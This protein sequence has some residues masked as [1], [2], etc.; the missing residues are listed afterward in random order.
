VLILSPGKIV[1][2]WVISPVKWLW[3]ILCIDVFVRPRSDDIFR[4]RHRWFSFAGWVNIEGSF[5]HSVFSFRLS[6]VSNVLGPGVSWS[7]PRAV[8]LDAEVVDTSDESKSAIF[9]PV[10][11]PWV[12]NDPILDS[13][14]LSPSSDTDVVV[15]L[16]STSI[17]NEDAAS[18][19]SEGVSN[20]NGTSDGSSLIDLVDHILLSFNQSK[21]VNSI[22]LC[23]FLSPASTVGEAVLALDLSTA[24]DTVIMSEGLIRG[25][26]LVSDVVVVDPLI[27]ILSVSSTTAIVWCFAG[28]EDLW[29]DVN[30]RPLGFSLDLDTIGEGWGWGEC[31]AWAAVD[32]DVLVPLDGKIV[33]SINITPPV[34]FG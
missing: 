24:S 34:I 10:A 26:C 16:D 12:S 19:V 32:G 33:G 2:S 20:S 4:K 11:S 1:D 21:F 27:S 6:L 29:R 22:D 13:V 3:E 18:V 23:S 15:F 8:V 7:G 14:L 17:I 5:W 28:D 25:A 30:I 31:P 9:S